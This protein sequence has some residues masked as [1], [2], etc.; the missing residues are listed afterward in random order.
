MFQELSIKYNDDKQFSAFHTWPDKL[1]AAPGIIVVHEIWGLNENIKNICNRFSNEGFIT[2]APDLLGQTGVL[3]K[4]SPSIFSQLRNKDT[5]HEAQA[6][7]RDVMQPLSTK[8]FYDDVLEKLK[9][10]FNFLLN[11]PGMN[12]NIGIIGFCFGGT[13]SFYFAENEPRLKACVSF[14]GKQPQTVENVTKISCPV[15]AFYGEQDT[16]LTVGLPELADA[17]K[18]YG[19]DFTYLIYPH[20]GHAFFNNSN[21]QAYNQAAAEDAW[22]KTLDFFKKYLGN[23]FNDTNQYIPGMRNV[24]SGNLSTKIFIGWTGLGLTIVL[25][26]FFIIFDLTDPWGLLLFFPILT[27]ALGFLQAMHRF[28][29]VMAFKGLFNFSTGSNQNQSVT[30]KDFRSKDRLRALEIIIYAILMALIFSLM[31]YVSRR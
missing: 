31:V 21:Q 28:S 30:E 8:E 14:Y 23:F 26:L 1:G 2:I 6:K 7:M 4:I 24:G 12:G 20:A 19:K 11:D 9:A 25:W 18:K 10:C 15:L 22:R 29:I 3:E 16:E 5:R 13:T 17:M 27:A